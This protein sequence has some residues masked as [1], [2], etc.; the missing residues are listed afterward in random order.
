MA[1]GY[2]SGEQPVHT[3]SDG[4]MALWVYDREVANRA[5]EPTLARLRSAQGYELLDA[6]ELQNKLV[7]YALEDRV[8]VPTPVTPRQFARSVAQQS[9][10]T[11]SP[12]IDVGRPADWFPRENWLRVCGS[13]R[14]GSA[15]WKLPVEVLA[16]P[17]CW[18]LA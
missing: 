6:R 1:L 13:A 18:S 9:I 15:E 8:V 17:G 7:E 5:L 16:Y 14:N 11:V 2:G 4:D 10:L 12:R 3:D